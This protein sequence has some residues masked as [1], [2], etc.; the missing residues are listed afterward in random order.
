M[1]IAFDYQIFG[2]HEYSGISRY[3]YEL[4]R[5]MATTYSQDVNIIAPLYVNKYLRKTPGAVNIWGIPIRRIPKTARLV[6]TVNSLLIKPMFKWLKPDIVHE[7]Y[8]TTAQY[9]PNDAKVILTV[10]DMIHE[11]FPQSFSSSDFTRC[12]KVAAIARADHVICISKQ[13]QK[14]LVELLDVD[15]NKTSV[16]YLGFT[17]TTTKSQLC[18]AINGRPYL[19]YVGNRNGYKNFEGLL[20]AFAESSI[21]QTGYRIVCFGGGALKRRERILMS[22]L[23]FKDSDIFQVSGSDEVLTGLYQRAI[24]FVYPSLYEGFGIP[25][26]EAMSFDCP[27]ACS[28]VSSIPEVVGGAGAYF[29]PTN[30]NDI[31]STIENL[32]TDESLRIKLI[33]AGRER[34]KLF[35]WKRCA[36]E[37]LDVYQKVLGEKS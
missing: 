16:V 10:Y 33:T 34:V 15:P 2:M 1:K 24:A 36:S 27:V 17:L 30:I 4:A 21:L 18:D 28:S 7:T 26:L 9:A 13:T 5:E 31:R 35:S 8:Y 12:Q 20:R 37:T 23:G 22:K 32:V 11:R 14:D 29:D 3:L 6:Q 19:L 25:P